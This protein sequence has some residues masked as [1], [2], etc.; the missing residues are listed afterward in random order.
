MKFTCERDSLIKEVSIAQEIIASRNVLSIL[1]NVLLHTSGNTLTVKATDLKV[2]FETT[3]EVDAARDG[4]TTVFL[5][6][7][8][9]LGTP[10]SI[11]GKVR[12]M[13]GVGGSTGAGASGGVATDVSTE[14][15][16]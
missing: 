6:G 2:A 5:P 10:V 13:V 9:R 12:R 11:R 4:A 8:Y 7:N 14:A 1:S 16:G 15:C 3:I